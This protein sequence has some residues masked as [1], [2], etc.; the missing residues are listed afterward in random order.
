MLLKKL[1]TLLTDSFRNCLKRFPTTICFAVALSLF[2][3]YLTASEG[4]GNKRALLVWKYYLAV[5]TLL[6]LS[7]HLWAEEM[8]GRL[9]K[10]RTHFIG[11][12]LLLAD[13]L[14]LYFLAKEQDYT[15]WGIAHAAVV[16]TIGESVFFLSFLKEKDDIACR[17]FTYRVLGCFATAI[18]IG[19]AMTG[20]CSL[21]AYSLKMLFGMEISN[22]CYAY[23]SIAGSVLLPILLFIGMLPSGADK[24]D[25]EVARADLE[26]GLVRFLLL[27]LLGGYLAVLYLYA[28]RILVQWELPTGWVSWLTVVLMTG[29]IAVE[30]QLYPS[31]MGGGSRTNERIARWLPILVL[32]LLVLMTVG[33]LRRF[34]D[35]GITV[36]RLYLL[37][38]NGWFYVVCI[39]LIV[40]KARRIAWIPLSFAL[41]FLLTSILPVNYAGITKNVLRRQLKEK[42]EASGL[43]LPL[44]L[45]N[46]RQWIYSFP[47]QEAI[48][49]NDR[50][51]Y[52]EDFFGQK[53]VEEMIEADIPFYNIQYDLESQ[54]EDTLLTLYGRVGTDC[55]IPVPE[56]FDSFTKISL[57]ATFRRPQ[58]DTLAVSV[59]AYSGL[60]QDSLYISLQQLQKLSFKKG[61]ELLV[62]VAFFPEEGMELTL[63]PCSRSECALALTY[64]D[65]TYS[66][67]P[68]KVWTLLLDGYLFKKQT[69][70][71]DGY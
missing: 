50:F 68:E 31:R 29:C 22:Q 10:M 70:L 7:L 3:C 65:L 24:H 35:Y 5:G 44:T 14:C 16:F 30:W 51:R 27:P 45:E 64:F 66:D 36:S 48:D 32:P 57:Q 11:H 21:L 17:N 20:G 42:V 4:E 12:A 60:P 54:K 2:L 9:R 26:N 41:L 71:S 34:S 33:I 52:L 39:G 55:R 37:T 67:L 53:N 61:N 6:S 56:G 58:N 43:P 69:A 38:L 19:L 46:Y 25:R 23:I 15:E 63:H 49:L 8:Q 13:A 18:A 47:L 62:D 59:E 40:N 1:S 28:A